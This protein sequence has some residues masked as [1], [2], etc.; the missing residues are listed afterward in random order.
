MRATLVA[1]WIESIGAH[2]KPDVPWI[3]PELMEVDI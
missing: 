2:T 3:G 1:K